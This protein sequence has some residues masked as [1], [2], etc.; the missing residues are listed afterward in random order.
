MD[1]REE[2]EQVPWQDLLAEA[3]PGDERRR[4]MYLGAGLVGAMLV[5]VVVART[6]WEPGPPPVPVAPSGVIEETEPTTEPVAVPELPALPLYSEADLMALPPDPA[7][8]AA[9]ARAEWFVVDYFTADLDPSGSADVRSALP[10]GAVS[11]FPQDGVDGVSYVEWARAFRVEPQGDGTYR[12]GVVFRTLAAP[13]DRGFTRQPVRAV[14]VL[15]VVRT[16]GGSAVLD[17]P[18][19]LAMPAG[20]EPADLPA[21]TPDPPADVVAEAV[22]RAAAW[23]SEPRVVSA[24]RL[25]VG[26]R[27]VVSVADGAGNRWPLV[28]RVAEA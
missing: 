23:G 3:E 19:P 9:M 4:A 28:V 24:H 12:V 26:W 17:L 15:V 6:W 27:V 21:E 8:R 13:P 2:L 11:T 14:E 22:E 20:P 7:E 25:T 16:D 10:G 5:G 1:D 18:S